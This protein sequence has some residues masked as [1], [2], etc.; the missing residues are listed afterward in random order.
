MNKQEWLEAR[1]KGI[2][3]SDAAVVL[4]ISPWKSP[5]T[6]FCEKTGRIQEEDLSDN[7]YVYWG[8]ALEKAIAIRFNQDCPESKYIM[9]NIDYEINTHKIYPWMICT[10]DCMVNH[11]SFVELKTASFKDPDE[12]IAEIPKHYYAQ[13][14]HC[15]EVMD[16]GHG[17][18]ACFFPDKMQFRWKKIERDSTFINE[19]K[20]AEQSFWE[21]VEQDDW[22]DIDN[23]ASTQETFKKLF[24]DADETKE[25]HLDQRSAEDWDS[26]Q[27]NK[28]AIKFAEKKI[29]E[30]S[31]GIK[32]LLKDAAYG[33]LPD[34]R[35]ISYKTTVVGPKEVKGYSFRA[36]REVKNG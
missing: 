18:I 35:K 34:G 9:T 33:I 27:S 2:G 6:L 7:E 3:G 29:K 23:S 24:P 10:L 17:Y 8:S 31:A 11:D 19:M 1:K 25:V 30:C 36:L 16:Y 20:Q 13:V 21:R 4:G 15:I 22:P 32:I 12:W 14:Q 28:E 5:Y 26:I